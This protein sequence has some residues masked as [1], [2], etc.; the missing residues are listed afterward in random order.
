MADVALTVQKMVSTGI[1]PS[2]TGS[3]S[4]SNT[5]QVRNNGRTFV[6]FKKSEAADCVVTVETPKLVAGLAVAEQTVT[7]PA[8]TGD[9]MIGPFPPSVYNDA[10]GDVNITLSNIAGLTV[11]VVTL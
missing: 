11:A 1:T 10:N 5:Y 8:S 9:K 4:T 6:H 2:Y 3:L 7:V